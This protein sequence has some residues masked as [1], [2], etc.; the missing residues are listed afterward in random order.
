MLLAIPLSP[1]ASGEWR[2][3]RMPASAGVEDGGG[4]VSYAS[5]G[6]MGSLGKKYNMRARSSKQASECLN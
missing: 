4:R 2:R 6:R 5:G 3:G 1:I